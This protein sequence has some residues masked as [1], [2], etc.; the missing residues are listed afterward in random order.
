MTLTSDLDSLTARLD[1]IAR[2]STTHGMRPDYQAAKI[3]VTQAEAELRVAKVEAY[4]DIT[5]GLDY[6]NER[7]AFVAPIGMKQDQFLGFKISIPLPVRNKNQGRI[8]EQQAAR[9][10]AETELEGARQR[11]AA[12]VAQARAAADQL[13]PVLARYRDELIPLAE[14]QFQAVQRAYK[15]GQAGIAPV[16]QARQQRLSLELDYLGYLANRV[17]ALATLDAALGMNPHLADK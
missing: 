5:A 12:E 10:Q 8:L 17:E 16:F 9:R 4:G 1:D 11:I 7:S 6:E 3:A 14:K 15:Q 2:A 13:E